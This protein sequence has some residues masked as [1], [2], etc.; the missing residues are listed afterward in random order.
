MET[1]KNLAFEI[2]WTIAIGIILSIAFFFFFS[3][4]LGIISISQQNL[5]VGVVS[6][7]VTTIVAIIFLVVRIRS[8][9][10]KT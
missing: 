5:P 1:K 3:F 4:I 8:I 10:S 6:A 2:I 7:V 9:I